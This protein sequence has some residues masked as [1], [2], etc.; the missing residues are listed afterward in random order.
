MA[1]DNVKRCA[2][3]TDGLTMKS[4]V[5]TVLTCVFVACRISLKQRPISFF[6]CLETAHISLKDLGT[7]SCLQAM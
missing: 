2:N 7:S 5:D 3:K 1:K 4:D 6:G